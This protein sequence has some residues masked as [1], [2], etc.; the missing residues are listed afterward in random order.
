MHVYADACTTSRGALYQADTYHVV[1][2]Q[3]V[4]KEGTPICELEAPNTT[5]VIKLWALTLA[6]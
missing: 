4:L 1:F 2:P 6:G 5:V 3:H